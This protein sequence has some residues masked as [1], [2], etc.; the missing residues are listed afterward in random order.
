MGERPSRNH[1]DPEI[2]YGTIRSCNEVVMDGS[3]REHLRKHLGVLYVEMEAAGLADK[4]SCSDSK[5]ARSQV[6]VCKLV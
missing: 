6:D 5:M 3:T 2:C 4:R 1:T